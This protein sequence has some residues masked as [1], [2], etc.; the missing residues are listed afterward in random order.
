M[1]IDVSQS[2]VNAVVLE[3]LLRLKIVF[4]TSIGIRLMIAEVAR[5]TLT[6]ARASSEYK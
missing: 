1:A 5:E 3:W 2:Y 4:I 6:R